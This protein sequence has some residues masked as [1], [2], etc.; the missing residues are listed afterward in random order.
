LSGN[1]TA[2][3]NWLSGN[4]SNLL[5]W[6][7]GN[8][9]SLQNAL[10][11]HNSNA[12]DVHGVTGTV[13]GSEDVDD[14]PVNGE[15]TMPVSSNWAFDH[16]AASLSSSVHPN[17]KTFSGYGAETIT[18]LRAYT[19]VPSMTALV[20]PSAILDVSDWYGASGAYRP[21]DADSTS[22]KIED[23]DAA[24]PASIQ[25]TIVKWS[26]DAAGTLNT[27]VGTIATVT[28][29]D[30][31]TIEKNSGVNFAA[32]YYYWIKHSELTIP[33][34]GLYLVTGAVLFLPAE[35]D[36]IFGVHIWGFTGTNAPAIIAS[37]PFATSV[38]TYCQPSAAWVV[39]LTAGQK[40]FLMAYSA[41]TAG[42]PTLYYTLANHN[43]L[44]I[45]MLQQTA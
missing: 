27:G 36:K 20:D 35:V 34:T 12:T 37:V 15:T 7:G 29:S 24:F 10:T 31:L 38:A 8:D 9:T 26:S 4:Y 2:I 43:P 41:G 3:T 39:P 6:L 5:S 16:N 21:A 11:W 19:K 23:D 25:Y 42:M 44:S 45:F 22:T 18:G 1:D 28:D 33:A 40:I 13:L 17:L 14:T 32:S 30:T